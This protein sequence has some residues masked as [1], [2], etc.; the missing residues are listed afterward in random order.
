MPLY[1]R[2]L[3]ETEQEA[4][5]K[6]QRSREAVT[7][8]RA[9]IIALSAAGRTPHDIAEQVGM[10]I[11]SV[12]YVLRQA[13]RGALESVLYPRQEQRGPKPRLE[14]AQIAALLGLMHHSPADYG[15]ATQRW[16]LTDLAEIAIRQGVIPAI[17]PSRLWRVLTAHGRSWKQAKRRM[18]SPDPEYEEKKGAVSS[19]SR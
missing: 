19:L 6:A 1:I 9:R 11:E 14:A 8:R 5:A 15:L 12:R 10:H 7:H 3:T 4:V 13:N 17:S 18:T 2:T 16:T